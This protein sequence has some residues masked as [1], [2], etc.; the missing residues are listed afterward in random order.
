MARL[1]QP[2]LAVCQARPGVAVLSLMRL[3]LSATAGEIGSDAW[4]VGI[5]AGIGVDSAL[6]YSV[7][8]AIYI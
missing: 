7:Y 6:I 1:H 2:T 5:P 3:E 4:M 8:S